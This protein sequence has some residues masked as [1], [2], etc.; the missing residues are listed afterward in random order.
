MEIRQRK[1]EKSYI[2]ALLSQCISH[3]FCESAQLLQQHAAEQQQHNGKG[4]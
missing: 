1:T 2:R 3:P 4:I